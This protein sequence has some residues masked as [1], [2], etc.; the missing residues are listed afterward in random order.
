[1]TDQMQWFWDALIFVQT[2][3]KPK[4][5]FGNGVWFGTGTVAVGVA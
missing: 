4:Q 2:S 3:T 1:M 5:W